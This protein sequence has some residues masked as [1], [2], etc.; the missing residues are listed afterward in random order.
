MHGDFPGSAGLVSLT[1]RFNEGGKARWIFFFNCFNSFCSPHIT[2][3]P[4][5]ITPPARYAEAMWRLWKELLTFLRRERK[6][7]LAPLVVSLL[8]ITALIVFA[9]SS[10]LA[11]F[12]YPFL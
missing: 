3:K 10:V 12:V 4:L 5:E 8:I 7:W 2:P 1:P 6:W 9:G 11:P